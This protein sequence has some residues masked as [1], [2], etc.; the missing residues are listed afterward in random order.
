[1]EDDCIAVV[2]DR[3][4]VN[5]DEPFELELAEWLLAREVGN[6]R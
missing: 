1:M 5:I 2:I 4:L 6:G 3:P